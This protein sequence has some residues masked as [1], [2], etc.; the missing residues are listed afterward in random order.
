MRFNDFRKKMA[1]FVV[2]SIND[3]RMIDPGFDRRRLY[4]WRGKGYIRILSERYYMFS[5]TVI[6]E[7]VLDVIANK[8]YAPSYVSLESVLSRNGLLPDIVPQITSV[9][10]RKT[11]RIET[12]IATFIYRTIA[13]RLFF[14][15]TV[16]EK[17]GSRV[18]SMEKALLDYLYLHPD[19]HTQQDYESLRIDRQELSAR[20]EQ[21]RFT[22]LLAQFGIKTLDERAGSFMKWVRYA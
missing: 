19:L 9:S 8:M 1:P 11:R 6:D 7:R 15:Y 2:F 20:L 18:A 22:I 12:E 13:P 5:D 4:E 10:T 17:N 16:S 21:G 3:V 14:G